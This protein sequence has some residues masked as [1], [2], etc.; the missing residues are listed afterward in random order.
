METTGG[1]EAMRVSTMSK[2]QIRYAFAKRDWQHRAHSRL[3]ERLL[4]FVVQAAIPPP[5]SQIQ[6]VSSS[7]RRARTEA[8]GRM[9][10]EPFV[11]GEVCRY[12]LSHG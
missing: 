4:F 5:E 6:A 7:K 3:R 8:L 12:P 10:K 9:S 11:R 2:T 1:P